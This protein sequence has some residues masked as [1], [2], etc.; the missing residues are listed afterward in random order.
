[1]SDDPQKPSK[2]SQPLESD[3]PRDRFQQAVA[4]KQ[5]DGEDPEDDIWEGSFSHLA[6]IGTWISGAVMTVALL[7]VGLL[8]AM[9]GTAW[10]WMIAGIGLMWLGMAAWYG[11]RR[12]SIHYTLTS[13]RLVT[14]SGLLWR[15]YDRVELIDIDDVTYRQGPIERLLGIGTIL[16]SSSDRT[17]PELELPGIEH[18]GEVADAIDDARRKER[19][20]RGLHIESV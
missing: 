6:M 2:Q 18:A 14:E 5:A 4:S 17:T 8:A 16:V 3:T 15:R 9:S 11:Y 20:N 13:Q 19:R 1:M 12:L 7:V 10:M